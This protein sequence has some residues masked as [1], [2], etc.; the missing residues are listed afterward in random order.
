MWFAGLIKGIKTRYDKKASYKGLRGNE[1]SRNRQQRTKQHYWSI[2]QTS[3]STDPN[4]CFL[5]I[6]ASEN[7]S[8]KIAPHAVLVEDLK[9][10]SGYSHYYQRQINLCQEW[11]KRLG[12][13]AAELAV[14]HLVDRKLNLLKDKLKLEKLLEWRPLRHANK[15]PW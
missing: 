10:E 14:A 5:C 7:L 11:K 8:Y 15:R 3:C 1:A 2:S 9:P 12:P 13:F 4:N 6:W